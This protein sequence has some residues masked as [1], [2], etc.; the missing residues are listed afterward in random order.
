MRTALVTGAGQGIGAAVARRLAAEGVAVVVNDRHEDWADRTVHAITADGGAAI[1]VAGDVSLEETASSCVASALRWRGGLDY[2]FNNAGVP[3]VIAPVAD[4]P[5]AVFWRVLQV[6]L[7]GVLTCMKAE[8]AAMREGGGGAIVNAAS[9]AVSGGVAG[10]SAYA[11]SKHAIVGL[12]KSAA[13]DHAVDGIRVNAVAPGLVDSGFVSEIDQHRFA[14]GHPVGRAAHPDE[15]AA[16]VCWLLSGPSSFVTGSVL[17]V[18][19]G[20][21]AQVAG[22]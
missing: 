2:A 18:D 21:S 19:G 13:L 3:G 14:Q 6:N 7:G 17:A 16:A 9:A 12:T 5:M 11:A 4:Y 22:L 1:A 10:S 20:L 8:I 15:V